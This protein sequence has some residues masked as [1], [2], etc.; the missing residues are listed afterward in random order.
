MLRLNMQTTDFAMTMKAD[1]GKA[2]PNMSEPSTKGTYVAPQSRQKVVPAQ[3]K[4]NST[5]S[6]EAVG[7][8]TNMAFCRRRGEEGRSRLSEG[9]ARRMREGR[10]VRNDGPKTNVIASI[11]KQNMIS[12]QIGLTVE[13]MPAPE[14]IVA[15]ARVEGTIDSGVDKMDITPGR[16]QLDYEPAKENI[17][18]KQYASTKISVTGDYDLYA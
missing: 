6:R 18:V 1:W 3:V 4:I 8:Y 7:L 12:R 15:P 10:E 2:D 14:I 17:A 13:N 9:I 5:A 16:Y 11:A